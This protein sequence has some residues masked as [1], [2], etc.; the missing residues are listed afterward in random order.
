MTHWRAVSCLGASLLA[1]ALTA[2]SQ[3]AD[4][5]ALVAGC[6]VLLSRLKADPEIDAPVFRQAG[7]D[8]AFQLLWA[9]AQR[10]MD[11]KATLDKW[12]D[13]HRALKAVVA[14][15]TFRSDFPKAAT[16]A[17]FD[18][19]YYDTHEGDHEAGLAAARRALDLPQ[20]TG[21]PVHLMHK[22]I[23][24]ELRKLGRLRDAIDEF[25]EADR[26]LPDSTRRP[27]RCSIARRCKRCSAWATARAPRGKPTA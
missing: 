4:S 1:V 2:F 19:F 15:G 13:L 10:G 20:K 6:K 14:L 26:A 17:F 7:T 12:A 18:D 21:Q 3:D 5:A 23:G 25:R 16:Y 11:A 24:E 9:V 27:L 8:H 22:A